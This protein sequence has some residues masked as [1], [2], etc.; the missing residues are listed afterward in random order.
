MKL[1]FDLFKGASQREI[2]LR[3]EVVRDE[4]RHFENE[5]EKIVTFSGIG[6]SVDAGVL[7]LLLMRAHRDEPSSTETDG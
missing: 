1:P 6:I 4:L 3:V 2:H 7:A 5:C